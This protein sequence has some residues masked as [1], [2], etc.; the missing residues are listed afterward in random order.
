MSNKSQLRNKE[1]KVRL[2]AEEHKALLER[3]N[4][5]SLASWV[6]ETCLNEKPSKK[7]S[8]RAADPQL[9]A[10]LGRIGGN[11]NQIARQANTVQS[12]IEKIRAF[13]ELATIRE[14][15]QRILASHD[16]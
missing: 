8:Y 13:A 12:D 4:T 10:A 15:L 6:R 2:T 5:S 11:L 14:Q 1:I 3:C 9:L 7:R 16:S